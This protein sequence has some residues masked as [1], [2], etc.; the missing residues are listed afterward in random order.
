MSKSK[1][2]LNIP[3]NVMRESDHDSWL[4][5]QREENKIYQGKTE[6]AQPYCGMASFSGEMRNGKACGYGTATYSVPETD[7]DW[8]EHK[9]IFDNNLKAGRGVALS[10]A[11]D[12]YEGV[13]KNNVPTGEFEVQLAGTK[14]KIKQ[15]YSAGKKIK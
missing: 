10:K 8:K 2:A 15:F 13:W 5:K 9:G 7:A 14:T 6:W 11:G 12:R 1:K 4:G 3:D